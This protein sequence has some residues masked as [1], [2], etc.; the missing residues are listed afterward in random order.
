MKEKLKQR[1][2]KKQEMKEQV[3]ERHEVEQLER[4]TEN[5]RRESDK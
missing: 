1:K 4:T 5:V 3:R 2:A